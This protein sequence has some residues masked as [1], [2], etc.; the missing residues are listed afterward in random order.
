MYATAPRVGLTRIRIR[1]DQ[2]LVIGALAGLLAAPRLIG[3]LPT[4]ALMLGAA[5]AGVAVALRPHWGVLAMLVACSTLLP[6]RVGQFSV[7]GVRSDIPEALLF[8]V[9]GVWVLK[10]ARRTGPRN[11]LAHPLVGMAG[12]GCF[13]AVVAMASGASVGDVLGP[14]KA[15]AFWLL[16]L[17]I[18]AHVRELDD[19]WLERA[20]IV[21]ATS[22]AVMA[23]GLAGAGISL[24]HTEV[25][26]V[27]TLGVAAEAQRIR[28]AGL[29]LQF[30]ATFLL[31][32]RGVMRGW[33]MRSVAAVAA[34]LVAQALS[35]NRSTWASLGLCLILYALTHPGAR[36]RFRGLTTVLTTSVVLA[37][38]FSLAAFGVLGPTP[39][40]LAQRAASALNP[41]VFSERSQLLRNEESR[42]ALTTISRKPITGVGLN[43][44]YGSRLS[45]Y[46]QRLAG[47]LYFDDQ[48]LHNSYLKL[49]LEAGLPGPLALLALIVA[50]GRLCRSQRRSGS[51]DLS[52][53]S[54]AVSLALL[55]LALQA[56][57]QTMLYHRPTLVTV[58]VAL[59]L[60]VGGHAAAR[61]QDGARQGVKQG[62][63][64]RWA[65]RSSRATELQSRSRT[66]GSGAPIR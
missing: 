7:A 34:L 5:L 40:S 38:V 45:V 48:T 19:A 13:G 56:Y 52:S 10:S 58:A 20:V 6:T 28:P 62:D 15:F 21:L 27:V 22:T 16:A 49:W 57:Y 59:A 12:A 25:S 54:L 32:H 47:R 51:V 64:G 60:L 42:I 17:A 26:E 35:F 55:G 23:I 1:W 41:A 39:R 18:V 30:L 65:V 53:R 11:P 14:L 66:A 4:T 63:Q 37:A 24:A 2:A 29:Q 8:L 44:P 50:S 36:V 46:S 33:S 3:D 61:E 43:Q 31:V 9:L